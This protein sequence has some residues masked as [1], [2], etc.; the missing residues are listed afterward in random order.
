M[1]STVYKANDGESVMEVTNKNKNSYTDRIFNESHNWN[2][3]CNANGIEICE[4][5]SILMSAMQVV[6]KI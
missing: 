6:I 3:N 4:L 5:V 2:E 1:K